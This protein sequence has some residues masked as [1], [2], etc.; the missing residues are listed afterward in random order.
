M[1]LAFLLAAPAAM[2]QERGGG[3]GSGFLGGL[4]DLLGGKPDGPAPYVSPSA[5][6]LIPNAGDVGVPQ[7]RAPKTFE[8]ITLPK[9]APGNLKAPKIDLPGLPAYA[10]QSAPSQN[11]LRHSASLSLRAVLVKGGA[12]VPNGLIWRLFSAVPSLEGRSPL[13]A[14]SQSATPS[15]DV[16]PGS[17]ILHVAFGRAGTVK[18]IDFSGL[19]TQEIIDLD[20]GGLKLNAVVGEHGKPIPSRLRFDVYAE[21]T[22]DA[23]R[24]IVANDVPPGKVLRLN[25]GS[26][27][28]VSH[29]GAVNAVVRA[30]IRVQAGKL[31]EATMTQ[32]AALLTMKLVREHG[33]EAIADTAWTITNNEGDLVGESVGAFP[34]MVLAA[35][36]YVIVARN[37]DKIYQRDFTVQAGKNTDV[38]VLTS[39]IAPSEDDATPEDAPP[40][41]APVDDAAANALK[42]TGD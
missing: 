34:S 38:E 27:Q 39:D 3:G 24:K 19:K 11:L 17:Y 37:N 28:V 32:R 5:N 36:D 13:I 40:D 35:G 16:P 42:A 18:R 2:A 26:Y 15:F 22:D 21:A 12:T 4:G 9:A 41:D 6:D 20:A 33:G 1:F 30:D 8:P 14:S 25:A 29:Y 23:E 31:T 7:A 10:P